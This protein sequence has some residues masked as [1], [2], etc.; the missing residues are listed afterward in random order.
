MKQSRQIMTF[1]F[2]C[3]TVTGQNWSNCKWIQNGYFPA[4]LESCDWWLAIK[5]PARFGSFTKIS[6]NDPHQ[7]GRLIANARLFM[8]LL[9]IILRPHLITA[10]TMTTIKTQWSS[11]SFAKS[12]KAHP[13]PWITNLKNRTRRLLFCFI[14]VNSRFFWIKQV[15]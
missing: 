10:L 14:S 13:T 2:R 1:V 4:R 7:A 15:R 8:L 3:T 12:I 5:R 11:I 6:L 9:I